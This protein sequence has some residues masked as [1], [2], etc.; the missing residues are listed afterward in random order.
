M[1][2]SAWKWNSPKF[3]CSIL[4]RETG[5]QPITLLGL[6]LR[7]GSDYDSVKISHAATGSG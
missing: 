2:R 7:T 1:H 4:H 3:L 5:A 6:V